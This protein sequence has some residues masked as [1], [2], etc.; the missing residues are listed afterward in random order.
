MY[1]ITILRIILFDMITI[2][3]LVILLL[4]AS[5]DYVCLRMQQQD[6]VVIT[7]ITVVA[8][9]VRPNLPYIV[10]TFVTAV[11]HLHTYLDTWCHIP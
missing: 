1:N 3:L 2:I 11:A 8:H 7:F 5:H 4:I 10:I 6:G 9:L